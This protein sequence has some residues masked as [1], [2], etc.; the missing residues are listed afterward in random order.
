MPKTRRWTDQQLSIAVSE[1]RSMNQV[2]KRLG[3]HGG[4]GGAP[5]LLRRHIQRLGLD[6]SHFK[7]QHWAKGTVGS[8]TGRPLEEILIKDGGY[9]NT[10]NIRQRLIRCGIKKAECEAC[11]IVEWFG[12]PAPLELDHQNGVRSDWRVENLKILCA[13][14]HAIKTRNNLVRKPRVWRRHPQEEDWNNLTVMT[15]KVSQCPKCGAEILSAYV[16]I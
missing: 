10:S 12:E 7:G 2:V 4:G 3:L 11:G 5:E 6:S 15:P 8:Q 13:N 14:C 16:N 1:S 9:L